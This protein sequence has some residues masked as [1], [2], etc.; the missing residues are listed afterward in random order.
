[1][2]DEGIWEGAAKRH[3]SAYS[4]NEDRNLEKESRLERK[5]TD[6]LTVLSQ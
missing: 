1:M 6:F 4:S 2:V 5:R 3:H